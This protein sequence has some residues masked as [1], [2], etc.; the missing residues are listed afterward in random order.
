MII[1]TVEN[2]DELHLLNIFYPLASNYII[3][4][5]IFC[6]FCLILSAFQCPRMFY[7]FYWIIVMLNDL[8]VGLYAL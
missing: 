7:L 8:V 5:Q 1:I 4:D 2:F 6:L 3:L